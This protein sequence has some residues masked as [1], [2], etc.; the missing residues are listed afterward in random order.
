MTHFL[1]KVSHSIKIRLLRIIYWWKTKRLKNAFSTGTPHIVQTEINHIPICVLASED[2][3]RQILIRKQFE[4]TDTNFITSI[5]KPDWVCVDIGANIGYWSLL[6][7]QG[8]PKGT[9][10][11]FEPVSLTHALLN[12]NIL[13]N[14]F[15]N[16]LSFKQALSNKT[17]ELTLCVAQDS[18]FSSFKDTQRIPV[19]ERVKVACTTLDEFALAQQVQKIDFIKIDVEGAE[20][21]ILQGAKSIL[22]TLNPSLMLIELSQKN[23]LA[24][25]TTKNDILQFLSSFGY[26]PFIVDS[27]SLTLRK[28]TSGDLHAHE[29]FFFQK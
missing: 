18:A 10:Y 8:C 15:T 5:M 20:L 13:L 7:A 19:K 24:Y 28:A 26:K 21:S 6:L 29:N 17:E 22:Q 1:K 3:G 11:A 16:V 27:N 12:L 23:L 4:I 14:N 9:I 25:Q 2:I